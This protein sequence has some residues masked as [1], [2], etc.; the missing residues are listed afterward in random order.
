MSHES[1]DAACCTSF[2]PRTKVFLFEVPV[3]FPGKRA[4]K[5]E[6]SV[7]A[8]DGFKVVKV[9]SKKISNLIKINIQIYRK[10]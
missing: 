9:R 8:A 3:K 5:N 7:V 10:I 1:Y 4:K 2:Y 6:E